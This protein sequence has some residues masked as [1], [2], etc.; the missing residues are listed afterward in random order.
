MYDFEKTKDAMITLVHDAAYAPENKFTSTVWDCHI[1]PV[2][3]HSMMLGKKLG[4]D[5]EVLELAALLH[6]Y[7]GLAD[8]SLYKDHHIHSADL[9]EEKLQELEMPAEKIQHIKDCILSHRGSVK[10]EQKTVEA[11]ILA[12]AD[13][14]SHITELPDMFYL[15]YHVH[16]LGT[17]E[18]AKWL[19]AKLN[20]SWNKIMPEGKELVQ[21][22]YEIAM[23]ILER[24]LS[25]K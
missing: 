13:A 21:E 5:L 7:A 11:K 8:F 6:D 17:F 19:Q 4:A 18:G 10:I 22:D 20:R 25:K 2:V 9:A 1:V 12:S 14:M 15:A 3:E 23:N 24:T 16:N